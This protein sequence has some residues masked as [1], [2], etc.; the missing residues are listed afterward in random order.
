[1]AINQAVTVKLSEKQEE[2]L[3]QLQVGTHTAL[4]FKQRAE[5]ILLASQGISNN[6]IGRIMGID[7]KS[8]TKWRNRYA[9][10]AQELALTES[11]TPR[12]LR[13]IIEKL[14][15]DERRSGRTPTFTDEQVACIIALSLQKP[16]EIGLPFSHWTLSLLCEEVIRRGIVPS[17]SPMQ[18][19]RF[20]KGARSEATSS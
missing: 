3:R 10:A 14:L 16:D 12:K 9:A 8:V 2:I 7:G 18:I 1:M 17:I 4:H 19:S 15:S 20:L 5:I 13:S 11:D 6:E